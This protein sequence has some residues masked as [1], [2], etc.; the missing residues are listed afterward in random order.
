MAGSFIVKAK[1][2]AVISYLIIAG[3]HFNEA[4]SARKFSLL[5]CIAFT[6][7]RK[8]RIYAERELQIGKK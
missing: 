8:K 2:I 4:T 3:L 5:G 7:S 6:I 1:A